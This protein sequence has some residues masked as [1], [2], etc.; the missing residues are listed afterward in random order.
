VLN[1]EL[2]DAGAETVLTA[3]RVP[4]RL[5]MTMPHHRPTP[6]AAL[7]RICEVSLAHLDDDERTPAQV[8]IVV[9]WATLTGA[10]PADDG[11]FGTDPPRDLERLLCDCS[12]DRHRAK[13]PPRRREVPKRSHP[14][15]AAGIA[16]DGGCRFPGCDR[17]P[18]WCRCIVALDRRWPCRHRRLCCSAIATIT[19]SI[20][21]AGS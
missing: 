11:E 2:G 3:I 19:S 15:S 17:P 16:R 21:R 13:Q 18:G 4:I 9:D 10:D 8:S 5:R 7:V 20:C 6:G 14:L 12:V 1:G